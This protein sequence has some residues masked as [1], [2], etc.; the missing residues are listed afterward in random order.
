MDK[1][2]FPVQMSD[3]CA[4]IPCLAAARKAPMAAEVRR[5]LFRLDLERNRFEKIRPTRCEYL[6]A[7]AL[8]QEMTKSVQENS[9]NT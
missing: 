3:L 4:V 1:I 5:A 9:A 7:C 2:S 8:I 6:Q